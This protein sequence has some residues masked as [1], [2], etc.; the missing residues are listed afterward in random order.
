MMILQR[1]HQAHV[2]SEIAKDNLDT[3]LH[4]GLSKFGHETYAQPQELRSVEH[5]ASPGF[6]GANG[7]QDARPKPPVA[8]D[9]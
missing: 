2:K 3:S 8:T 6:H 1:N 4:S 5:L 9:E 7:I